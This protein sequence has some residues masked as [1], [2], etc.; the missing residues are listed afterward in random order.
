MKNTILL[1][2]LL[3]AKA[4]ADPF[5]YAIDGNGQMVDLADYCGDQQPKITR[6]QLN[7][8]TNLLGAERYLHYEG[9]GRTEGRDPVQWEGGDDIRSPATI[10]RLEAID[11]G[12]G[13][14][15]CGG[16]PRGKQ[17]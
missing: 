3:Q 13:D 4:M 2:L 12:T 7:Y 9:R 5:C 16:L 1:W 17:Q 8:D 11:L 6:I 10:R 15:P 14:A